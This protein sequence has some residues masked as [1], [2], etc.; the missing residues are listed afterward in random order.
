MK[1]SWRFREGGSRTGNN[2]LL[3]AV[4]G[5]LGFTTSFSIPPLHP[6]MGAGRAT[7]ML[8]APGKPQ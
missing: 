7:V 5:A 6:I 3:A 8:A 2:V 4:G 1:P